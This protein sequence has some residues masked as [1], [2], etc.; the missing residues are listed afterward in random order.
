MRDYKKE[1]EKH[2]IFL[3]K[4]EENVLMIIAICISLGILAAIMEGGL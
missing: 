4:F 3:K 1:I 2:E